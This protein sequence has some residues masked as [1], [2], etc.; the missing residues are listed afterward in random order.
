MTDPV[1]STRHFNDR[2]QEPSEKV[3]DY[4]RDLKKLFSR[5]YPGEDS[6]SGPC[7]AVFDGSA[8]SHRPAA[9]AKGAPSNHEQSTK[10]ALKVEYA[11]Q[12]GQ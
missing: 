3:S 10:R 2:K 4:A 8:R 9:I 6:Q 12:F 5:A 7:P 11:L 1:A